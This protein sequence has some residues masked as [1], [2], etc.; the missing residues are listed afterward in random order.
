MKIEQPGASAFTQLSDAPNS[1]VGSASEHLAVNALE[2]GIDFVPEGGGGVPGGSD[3]QVQFNDGGA[4]GADAGLTYNKTTDFLTVTGGVHTPIVQAH[5]SAGI[6]IEAQGGADVALFGA[7]G[8]QNATF[9]DGVKLN[10]QTA[11]RILSTD[12][13][14]NIAALDTA[15]YPSL[16][17]L[18][19]L[20]GVTS[21]IQNQIGGKQDTLVSGT[22]IKTVNGTTLLGS[23]DL[24]VTGVTNLSY[25][26]ATRVIASDTGTDATLPLVSSGDAG[27][28]PASGGGT[29]NFLRAD[30]TWAA[31]SSSGGIALFTARKLV[32]LR[33]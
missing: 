30:G 11:S 20:K 13:S 17:E 29:A 14:S 1:Y 23:G 8:G 31:P 18:T 16:T 4:F 26:A 27:L 2:T 9:Y 6:V 24:A 21:A 19:Y 33:I 32:S 7:G 25:T 15:T 28:A 10:S 3:T 5:T 12:A 22:N